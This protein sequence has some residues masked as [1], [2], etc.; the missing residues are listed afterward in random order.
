MTRTRAG[1]FALGATLLAIQFWQPDRTNPPSDPARHIDRHVHVPPDVAAVLDRACRDCHSNRTRWPFYSRIAPFSW[2]VVAHVR[3]GRE[4]MNFSE[5]G[6]YDDESMADL[7]DA[8]CDEVRDGAMPLPQYAL[9]HRT[10]RL[11]NR[12]VDRLCTWTGEAVANLQ[13]G[14]RVKEEEQQEP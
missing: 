6:E 8:I 10:A 2:N 1:A 11:S 9:V 7:L 14:R 3:D 13:A 5:W 4:Q 12:D